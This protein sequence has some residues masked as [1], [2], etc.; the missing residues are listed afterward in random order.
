MPAEY[1]EKTEP[2]TPRRRQEARNKGQVARSQDISA[3]V[4]LTVAFL[5]LLIFGP[6]LW[7]SMMKMVSV[8]LGNEGAT[9]LDETRSLAVVAMIDVV[10]KLAPILVMMFLTLLA[11][12]YAQIG[13][14]WT[15]DP[16]TPSLQK[17]N[18]ISGIKR[19]F[20]IRAVMTASINF[21]KLL[22]VA[23]VA[24]VTLL[25]NVAAIVF[26]SAFDYREMM[27]LGSD[28]LFSLAIRLGLA[29]LLLAFIDYVWQRYKHERDLRM[30]K[31]EVKDEMRSMEGD[32]HIKRRRRQVQMQLAVQRLQ[33]DV[34]KADVVVTNPTHFA[35]AIAYD[36][37][38]MPAPRVV[39]KGADELA[40]RIRQIA[41]GAGIPIVERKALARSLFDA[42]DVGDYIPQRFYKAIAEI[43]AYVYELSGQSL[44]VR[45]AA[46]AGA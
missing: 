23:L 8:L 18:P 41:T 36:M 12:L 2:A 25:D 44:P 29:L 40:L 30:T 26:A 43:L 20:G 9:S 21:G 10:K 22:F 1:D 33:Q 46:T 28:L 37:D 27:L 42:V 4:L 24:Y 13:W 15:L 3:A 17:L 19:L 35:V 45:A 34:P 39:A 5:A 32:P 16:L 7:Q 6:A 38:S 31:E 14:L 11:V